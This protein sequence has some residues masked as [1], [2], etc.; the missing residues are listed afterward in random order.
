M[1]RAKMIEFLRDH[2]RYW[3]ANSWNIS[4]SYSA[5]VKIYDFVPRT[6]QDQAWQMLE[7]QDVF[8][9]INDRLATFEEE[10]GHRIC[11]NGRSN[12]YLVLYNSKGTCAGIDE[13]KNYEDMDDEELRSRYDLVKAFDQAVIDCKAIFLRYCRHYKVV[14]KEVL[15]KKTVKVL[16]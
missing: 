1:E 9:C 7:M 12:G 6:L 14:E 2:Q 11:F 3:T 5:R 13:D 16:V 10:H 15:V 8:D 4:T